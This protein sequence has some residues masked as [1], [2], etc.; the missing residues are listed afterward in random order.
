MFEI[1]F[2]TKLCVLFIKASI[3]I[4]GTLKTM[5]MNSATDSKIS[6]D[7]EKCKFLGSQYRDKKQMAKKV[8]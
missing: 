1:M 8:F 4:T 5:H 3:S 6:G 2:Q 7:S